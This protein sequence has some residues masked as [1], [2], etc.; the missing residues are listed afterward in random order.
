MKDR[1]H[2]HCRRALF[3]EMETKRVFTQQ[4][5]CWQMSRRSNNRVLEHAQTSYTLALLLSLLLYQASTRETAGFLLNT[6]ICESLIPVGR[7]LCWQKRREWFKSGHSAY[8]VD[9]EHKSKGI[10]ADI[11]QKFICSLHPLWHS[12]KRDSE[13]FLQSVKHILKREIFLLHGLS[14]QVFKRN[15]CDCIFKVTQ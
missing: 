14:Q 6:C 11:N 2:S 13:R 10:I 12:W 5:V 15:L 3:L 8:R 1:S 4:D 7:I 9:G